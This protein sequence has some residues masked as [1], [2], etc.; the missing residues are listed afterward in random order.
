MENLPNHRLSDKYIS[1][2]VTDG[3]EEQEV[4]LSEEEAELAVDAGVVSPPSIWSV[5]AFVAIF[6]LVVIIIVIL[7]VREKKI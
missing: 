5:I 3:M 1:E 6:I 2:E 4:V 7:V